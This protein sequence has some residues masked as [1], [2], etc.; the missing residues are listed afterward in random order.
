MKYDN[1]RGSVTFSS[2]CLLIDSRSSCNR[3]VGNCQEDIRLLGRTN[4]VIVLNWT[5]LRKCFSQIALRLVRLIRNVSVKFP[6]TN[7][8][9][10]LAIVKVGGDYINWWCLHLNP[11]SVFS[12]DWTA[13]WAYYHWRRLKNFPVSPRAVVCGK[14]EWRIAL[15]VLPQRTIREDYS[16]RMCRDTNGKCV[17][18]DFRQFDLG[19]IVLILLNHHRGKKYDFWEKLNTRHVFRRLRFLPVFPR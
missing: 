15:H 19:R 4:Q 13:S 3:R 6:K 12:D 10:C 7:L 8:R 16:T 17:L 5:V 18:S 1:L 2:P 11:R 14:I 9:L